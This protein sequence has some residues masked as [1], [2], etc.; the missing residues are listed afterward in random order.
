MVFG[1]R[2][3]QLEWW[4]GQERRLFVHFYGAGAKKAFLTRLPLDH[5]EN[6]R[7]YIEY[8][9]KG[10]PG[11]DPDNACVLIEDVIGGSVRYHGDLKRWVMIY[12]PN[13]LSNKILLRTAPEITGP[14]SKAVVLYEAQE[15]IRN[16]PE[17]DE[18]NFCYCGREHFQFYNRK[19]QSLLITYDCNAANFAKLVSNMKLY[20]PRVLS[21]RFPKRTD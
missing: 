2:S 3:E 4:N 7:E 13:F 11:V 14:W 6:P 16:A 1:L 21:I 10:K 19:N 8:F 12:G 17:Y 20:S 15:Q 9:A 5:L 18:G